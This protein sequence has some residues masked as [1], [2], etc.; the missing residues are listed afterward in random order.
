MR[1]W[2]LGTRDPLCPVLTIK[3]LLGQNF[4][5]ESGW[6]VLTPHK[7]NRSVYNTGPHTDAV[8]DQ[9]Y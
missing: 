2:A 9:S 8:T 6:F 5:R 3:V 7:T 4:Q 1:I